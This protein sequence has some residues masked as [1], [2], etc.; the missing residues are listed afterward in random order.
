MRDFIYGKPPAEQ[1]QEWQRSLKKEQRQLDKEIRDVRMLASLKPTDSVCPTSERMRRLADL[2]LPGLG[3]TPPPLLTREPARRSRLPSRRRGPSSSSSPSATT[4]NRLGCSHGRSSGPTSRL[5]DCTSPRPGSTRSVCSSP[6]RPVR[7]PDS[8][9]SRS[10]TTVTDNPMLLIPPAAMLK[11]TGSMQK[12]TEVMKLTN[13]LV[14]LPQ[15]NAAM[16]QMSM[17]M[18]KVSLRLGQSASLWQST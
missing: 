3:P 4:S 16:R 17:E 11:V 5:T 1:L 13:E 6:T 9:S 15:L 2:D 18:M 10:L 8:Q 14:K 7:L 12:S